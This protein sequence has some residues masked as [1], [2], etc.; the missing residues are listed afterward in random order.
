[1]ILCLCVR[2]FVSVQTENCQQSGKRGKKWSEWETGK[3]SERMERGIE[4][5]RA[6]PVG[7]GQQKEREG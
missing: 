2:P 1:M 3:D 6:R 7:E 5:R 4:R